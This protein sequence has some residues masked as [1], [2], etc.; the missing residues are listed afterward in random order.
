MCGCERCIS[1][2]IIHS[3][4]L[5]WCDQFKK[6][7]GS[8]PKFSTQKVWGK[9][10]FTNMKHINIRSCHIGVI[11]RTNNLIWHRQKCVRIYIQI[12]YYHI[13]NVSYDVV[14]NSQSLIFLTKKHMI[15]IPTLVHQFVFAF[16]I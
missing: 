11:F 2:K 15:N 1:S 12:M 3:S 16:I 13:G 14:P 6:N 4:L 9:S 10:K 8:K 7:Q 5:S